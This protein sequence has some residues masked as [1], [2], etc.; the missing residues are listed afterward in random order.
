V[1]QGE[2]MFDDAASTDSGLDLEEPEP[3]ATTAPPE[4]DEH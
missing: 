4:V 3:D 2:E 1:A